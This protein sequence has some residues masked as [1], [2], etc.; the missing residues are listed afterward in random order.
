MVMKQQ[1]LFDNIP[2]GYKSR[3]EL[4]VIIYTA[5]F[6]VQSFRLRFF[7]CRWNTPTLLYFDLFVFIRKKKIHTD[8]EQLDGE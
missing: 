7:D 6:T 4:N 2:V 5:L 8:L 1:N 3:D